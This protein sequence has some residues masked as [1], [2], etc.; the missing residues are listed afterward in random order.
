MRERLPLPHLKALHF[1]LILSFVSHNFKLRLKNGD[2]KGIGVFSMP[3]PFPLRPSAYSAVKS[4]AFT[5][6]GLKAA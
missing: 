4:N 6:K 2:F 3:S 5:R 1:P